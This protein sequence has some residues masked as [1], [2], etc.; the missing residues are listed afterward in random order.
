MSAGASVQDFAELKRRQ[1]TKSRERSA[2]ALRAR[3]LQSRVRARARTEPGYTPEN[4]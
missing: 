1:I 4:A 3:V 2:L